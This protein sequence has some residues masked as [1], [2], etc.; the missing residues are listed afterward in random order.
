[1]EITRKEPAYNKSMPKE[2][3]F[4]GVVGRHGG[5]YDRG[6]ADY[7]YGRPRKP[8]YYMEG[9]YNSPRVDEQNMTEG[10]VDEYNQGY[11]DAELDGDRK[12]YR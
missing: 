6:S 3:S 10:E 8:H 11:D 7:Y 4:E 12:E 9:T 1:M 2:Q 5:A